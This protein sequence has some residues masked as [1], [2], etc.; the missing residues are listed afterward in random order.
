[1]RRALIEDRTIPPTFRSYQRAAL[2]DLDGAFRELDSAIAT[3]DGFI[4]FLYPI[5]VGPI[6]KDP[7]FAAVT[8]RAGLPTLSR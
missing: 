6:R 2:G 1:M 4:T 5:Y 8:K 7:R 3:R